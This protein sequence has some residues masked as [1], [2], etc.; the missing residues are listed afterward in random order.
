LL[1]VFPGLSKT[2]DFL[3]VQTTLRDGSVIKAII[4][5]P[6]NDHMR[7]AFVSN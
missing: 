2:F 5:A 6:F 3:W 4:V 1:T 7:I